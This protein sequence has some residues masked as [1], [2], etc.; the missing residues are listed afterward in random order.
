MNQGYRVLINSFIGFGRIFAGLKIGRLTIKTVGLVGAMATLLTLAGCGGLDLGGVFDNSGPGG[1]GGNNA[2]ANQPAKIALLVP[3]SAPGQT[4]NIAAAM[5]K[6]AELALFEA[7]KTNV[8]LITKDTAG[9]PEGAALAAQ[10]AINEGVEII[11]GPL[12]GSE[13]AAVTPIAKARNIPV[14]AFSSV[15]KVAQPGIYLMSF[16]PEQEV[17]NLL[18]HTSQSG[19]K[20]LIAMIPQSQ[21]GAVVERALKTSAA[22]LGTKIVSIEYFNRNGQNLNAVSARVAHAVESTTNPAQAIFIPE[23]G[24]N[25]RAIGTALTQAGFSPKTAKVLGTG[26]WDGPLTT[27]TPIAFGG[28]YA[29]VSPQKVAQFNQRYSA[30][31]QAKPPRIASLAYDALSLSMAFAKAPIGTRFTAGQITNVEGFNGVN[32]LFRFRPDGRVERGLSILE[33]TARGTTIAAPAPSK[34]QYGF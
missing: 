29:G 31:Y 12:L 13:V 28:W 5:K 34:F 21:Y 9:T 8:T 22:R 2:G 17:N 15:S 25:L 7:G 26:L 33:V 16:L 4:A 23:G 27:G 32:G 11:L 30:S 1:F 20:S 18:R 3:L 14:I 19:I 24:Q 6:A 10:A